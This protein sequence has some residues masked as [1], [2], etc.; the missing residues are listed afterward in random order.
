MVYGYLTE[1]T[2][3]KIN[4]S[5]EDE[6]EGT[7][8]LCLYSAGFKGIGSGY[9]YFVTRNGES[10]FDDNGGYEDYELEEIDK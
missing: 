4:S 7:I 6:F 9:K 3:V 5:F 1:G 2:K 8:T 10:F